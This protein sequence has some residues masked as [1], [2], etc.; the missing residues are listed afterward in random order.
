MC[1]P[2]TTYPNGEPDSLSDR[3]DESQRE[4]D[5][6]DTKRLAENT[7]ALAS[8]IAGMGIQRVVGDRVTMCR[9]TDIEG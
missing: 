2:E 6:V 8:C 4:A 1:K 5:K 9:A 3:W 7:A